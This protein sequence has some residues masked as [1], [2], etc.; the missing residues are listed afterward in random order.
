[1]LK[2]ECLTQEICTNRLNLSMCAPDYGYDC[3]PEM[4]ECPPEE[5]SEDP[6]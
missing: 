2:I 3:N 4:G 1:M 5:G 6:Y